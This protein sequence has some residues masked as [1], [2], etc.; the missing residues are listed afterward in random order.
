MKGHLKGGLIGVRCKHCG[1]SVDLLPVRRKTPYPASLRRDR[2]PDRR[3]IR[4]IRQINHWLDNALITY[5]P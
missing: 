3:V 5:V 4:R 2:R 1:S